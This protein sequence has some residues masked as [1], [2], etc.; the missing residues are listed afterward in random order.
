MKSLLLSTIL[1]ALIFTGC[2][3]G[4]CCEGNLDTLSNTKIVGTVDDPNKIPVP[5]INNLP[6]IT[7]NCYQA[8]ANGASSYDPDGN[9]TNYS[10]SVDNVEV[11]TLQNVEAILPCEKN[12]KIFNVCLSVTDNEDANGST[13]QTVKIIDL[14]TKS[15]NPDHPIPTILLPIPYK[16]GNDFIFDACGF[17][18][19]SPHVVKDETLDANTTGYLWNVTRYFE[20]NTTRSHEFYSCKKY[21][22][23]SQ[24]SNQFVKLDVSLTVRFTD[25]HENTATGTYFPNEDASDL[26]KTEL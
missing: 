25:G 11:S 6:Q 9:I 4:V 10:W 18:D 7:S 12:Q 15:T 26:N 2:S 16:Y 13:C 8:N 3:E 20:D 1:S 23:W 19:F 5:K 21:I 24:E 14:D 17:Q 22:D